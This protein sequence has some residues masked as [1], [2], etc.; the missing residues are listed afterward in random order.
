M[1]FNNKIITK[2]NRFRLK[3]VI[4]AHIICFVGCLISLFFQ[5]LEKVNFSG[6]NIENKTITIGDKYQIT[7]F[8]LLFS[9]ITILFIAFTKSFL[10]PFF[11]SILTLFFVYITRLFIHYQGFDHVYDSEVGVGY[12]LLLFFTLAQFL[13][14]L[15]EIFLSLRGKRIL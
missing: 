6:G 3:F 14:I 1:N 9:F 7:V 13:I 2:N 4:I 5:F 15:V 10:W 8:V 12:K 11:T